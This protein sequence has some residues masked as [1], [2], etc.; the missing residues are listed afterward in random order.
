LDGPD[1]LKCY[2]HDL[3]KDPKIFSKR[4]FGGGSLMIWGAFV[5]DTIFN[6]H[7]MDGTYDSV[8]YTDMLEECLEPFMQPDWVFMQDG[9]S[10]HRSKHTMQWL[11]ERN[12]PILEWPANSPD[13]NLIENLWGIL[14]RAVFANGRQF[15]T[16]EELK[17]E[18]LK[19]WDMI[20]EECLTSLVKSMPN[21]IIDVISLKGSNTKY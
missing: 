17:A 11:K 18:I 2:W 6:L 20:R 10:I 1:G 16:K 21:R 13:L 15:N 14:T 19:Q 9:A 4:R 7:I 5:N 3:R 8:K 12:I